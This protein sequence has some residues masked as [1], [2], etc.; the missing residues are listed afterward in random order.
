VKSGL[1]VAVAV[2]ACGSPKSP[3]HAP[4][5]TGQPLEQR[6][7]VDGGATS[8]STTPAD[9]SASTAWISAGAPAPFAVGRDCT[10]VKAGSTKPIE[11]AKAPAKLRALKKIG[12]ATKDLFFNADGTLV[13]YGDLATQQRMMVPVGGGKPTALSS[14]EQAKLSDPA[15][16]KLVE[17]WQAKTHGDVLPLSTK[18]LAIGIGNRAELIRQHLV[19]VAAGT[20]TP[21]AADGLYSLWTA[22]RVDDHRVAFIGRDHHMYVADGASKQLSCASAKTTLD[23]GP[24]FAAQS[25]Y[26]LFTAGTELHAVD[27]AAGT[28]SVVAILPAEAGTVVI[29]PVP[30]APL[31]WN[32][33]VASAGSSFVVHV[34][35]RAA[36]QMQFLLVDAKTGSVERITDRLPGWSNMWVAPDGKHVVFSRGTPY[37]PNAR[38]PKPP[39]RPRSDPDGMGTC[40]RIGCAGANQCGWQDDGCWDYIWCGTCAGQTA[41]PPRPPATDGLYTITL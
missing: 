38:P 39:A 26:L 27:L 4:M 23:I 16:T 35:L 33:P 41:K 1:L 24:F 7:V 12:P 3:A 2:F 14:A 28:D 25:D 15:I 19:D 29:Q 34:E 18:Y 17:T 10:S 32:P 6:T 36:K 30:H 37:D 22:K 8:V 11:I 40:D 5:P 21:V 9:D 13:I 20:S 31:F